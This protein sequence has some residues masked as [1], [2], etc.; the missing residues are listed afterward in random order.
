MAPKANRR[1]A[2]A[3]PGSRSITHDQTRQIAP[4]HRLPPELVTKIFLYLRQTWRK[5]WHFS[6]FTGGQAP[7]IAV[8]RVCRRWKII[9]LGSPVLWSFIPNFPDC[10]SDITERWIQLSKAYP[11]TIKALYLYSSKLEAIP[12]LKAA[13]PRVRRLRVTFSSD[14]LEELPSLFSDPA[15]LLEVLSLRL[16]EGWEDHTSR[17]MDG[18]FAE[19][20]PRLRYLS[21]E[22]C[23][24]RHD[25]FL[26]ANL[27]ILEI[28]DPVSK[29]SARTFLS[30]LRKL[31]CLEALQMSCTLKPPANHETDPKYTPIPPKTKIVHLPSLRFLSM[32]GSCFVQD[33]DFLSHLSFPSTTIVFLSSGYPYHHSNLFAGVSNFLKVH[34]KARQ[35]FNKLVPT[36]I[37]LETRCGRVKLN[38]RDDANTVLC[39]LK[40]DSENDEGGLGLRVPDDTNTL[41]MFSHLFFPTVTT[42]TTNCY[43]ASSVWP[44]ISLSFP[45]VKHIEIV[46]QETPEETATILEAMIEDYET[47]GTFSSPPILSKLRSLYLTKVAFD[48]GIKEDLLEV[49]QERKK[50]SSGLKTIKM[51]KCYRVDEEWVESLDIDGLDVQWY[52]WEEDDITDPETEGEIYVDDDRMERGEICLGVVDRHHDVDANIVDD[53]EDI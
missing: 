27:K 21:I 45:E 52:D 3:T 24:V 5:K 46:M 1:R 37:E 6:H 43:I 44:I 30:V 9:A 12:S 11:L 36:E 32:N 51:E 7:W 8:L 35:D 42:F 14:S 49:L 31:T 20:T 15:P 50:A 23:D 47:Y 38:L 10:P 13:I 40:L 22:G 53:L 16:E 18:L 41:E 33:L 28:R 2:K 29:F 26:F 17:S 19:T 34:A 48:D 25:S 39:A 4:I